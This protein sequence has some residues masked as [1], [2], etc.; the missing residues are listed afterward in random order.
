MM[1]SKTGG[2]IQA[3]LEGINHG[4]AVVSIGYRLI[5]E[6]VFPG[7]ISDVKAAIRFIKANAD[8]T[9][10]DA[11]FRTEEGS[12]HLSRERRCIMACRV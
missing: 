9:P 10:P 11:Y 7:A 4:N 5:G 12:L 3:M 6:A 2:D 1:G 8:Q